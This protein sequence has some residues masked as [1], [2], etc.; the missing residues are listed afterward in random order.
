MIKIK[1][2]YQNQEEVDKFLLMI[3]NNVK[4]IKLSKNDKGRFKKAYIILKK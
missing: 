1:V 4:Q 2:S 3:G